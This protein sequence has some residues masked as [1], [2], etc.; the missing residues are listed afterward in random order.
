MIYMSYSFATKNDNRISSYQS[1]NKM[2]PYIYDDNIVRSYNSNGVIMVSRS[3]EKF[4]E[5]TCDAISNIYENASKNPKNEA[6]TTAIRKY[7]AQYASLDMESKAKVRKCM[8]ERN[9]GDKPPTGNN[10]LDKLIEL[11]KSGV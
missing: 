2:M 5:D 9:L 4:T 3:V 6:I 1:D 11:I 8:I 7:A 10:D